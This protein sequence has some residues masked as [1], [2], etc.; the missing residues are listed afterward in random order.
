MYYLVDTNKDNGCLRVIP[1]SHLKSLRMVSKG[2]RLSSS[3]FLK[4]SV[5]LLIW[6][7]PSYDQPLEKLT[8][9]SKPEM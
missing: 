1:G 9:K 6:I 8:W 7:I 5:G 4:V 2:N 3:G